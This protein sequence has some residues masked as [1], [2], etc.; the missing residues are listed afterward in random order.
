[1]KAVVFEIIKSEPRLLDLAGAAAYLGIS[2]SAIRQMVDIGRLPRVQLPSVRQAL[3]RLDRFLLDKADL[4]AI[5]E[6]AKER[7]EHC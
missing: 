7:Q 3:G 4:D 5:V 6:R 1:M 2:R